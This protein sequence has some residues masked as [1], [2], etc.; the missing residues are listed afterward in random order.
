MDIKGLNQLLGNIDIYLLDQILKGRFDKEMKILDAGC[1]EGRNCVYFLNGGYQIFGVDH[2]P[3]AIQMA[4]IYAQTIQKDYDFYRFQTSMVENIPFHQ[5]AFDVVI[6]SAVLHFAKDENQFLKMV[7]DMMR[8]LKLGGI[9]F[10]RM[11]TSQGNIQEISPHLGDGVY[12]LPDGSERFLLTDELEMEI[13]SKYKLK[14]LEPAK[15]VLVHGQRSM[16]VFVWEKG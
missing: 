4:R 15:S 1:G 13:V 8:V 2:N 7:D 3:I 9:F 12:L 14:Y 16:G 5:G 11:T 6:S 10:L